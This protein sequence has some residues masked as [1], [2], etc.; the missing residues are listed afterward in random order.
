MSLKSC[1]TSR[2]TIKMIMASPTTF[3]TLP[4]EIRLIIYEMALPAETIS[5]LKCLGFRNPN[6]ETPRP[7]I[8]IKLPTAALMALYTSNPAGESKGHFWRKPTLLAVC[9]QTKE[10]VGAIFDRLPATTGVS[11]MIS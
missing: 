2:L 7:N 9:Q 11:D 1:T 10:E 5:S 8:V 4:Y 3:L 6:I